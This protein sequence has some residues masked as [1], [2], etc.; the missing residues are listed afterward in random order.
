MTAHIWLL[1]LLFAIPFIVM[2]RCVRISLHILNNGMNAPCCVRDILS[3]IFWCCS[4]DEYQPECF[5]FCFFHCVLASRWWFLVRLCQCVCVCVCAQDTQQCLRSL[6]FRQNKKFVASFSRRCFSTDARIHCCCY[7]RLSQCPFFLNHI[8]LFVM[9]VAFYALSHLISLT[10]TQSA[11]SLFA[12][13]FSLVRLIFVVC[14]PER[15]CLHMNTIVYKYRYVYALVVLP[16]CLR[17]S[18]HA[19]WFKNV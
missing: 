10:H 16:C 4:L 17:Y 2:L 1:G 9:C 15:K 3:F 18:V 11:R 19:K 14:A 12:S 13:K 5:F 7:C 8:L 6:H